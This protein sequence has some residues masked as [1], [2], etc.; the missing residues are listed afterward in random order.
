MVR[1]NIFRRMIVEKIFGELAFVLWD[2]GESLD[3]FGVDDC[4]IE[5]RFRAVI[6]KNRINYFARAGRQAETYVADPKNGANVRNFFLDVADAFDGFH[7]ATDIILVARSAGENERVEDYIFRGNFI[8][9]GEQIA[10]AFGDSE[11]AFARECL[12]L[13]FILVDAA[14]DDRR[15]VITGQWTDAFEFF[16]AIFQV[17]RVDDAFA[18]AVSQR[19]LDAFWIGGIDH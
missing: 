15:A 10:R 7:R 19:K 12:R 5:S 13:E 4:E 18:L 17:D 2:R 14:D 1:R 8:F 16:F 6:K 11:F 3:A 9:A